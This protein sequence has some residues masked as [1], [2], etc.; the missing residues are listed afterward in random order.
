MDG[1]DCETGDQCCNGFC[2]STGMGDDQLICTPGPSGG[3]SMPQESCETAADCCDTTN[4]CI[5]GFCAPVPPQ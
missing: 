2:S 4:L 5:N 1:E 3:C